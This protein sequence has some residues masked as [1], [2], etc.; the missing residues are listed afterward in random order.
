MND[1]TRSNS[2]RDPRNMARETYC[3]VEDLDHAVSEELSLDVD[4]D[5]IVICGMGGSAIGGDILADCAFSISDFPIK[6][7]RF[8]ELPSWINDRTLVIVSS[9]SG[10]TRETI[11]MYEQAVKRGCTTIVITSGG[12]LKE[13]AMTNKNMIINIKEGL[14]PRNALGFTMGYMANVID[15]V[16]GPK[17]KAGIK[18]L[19]PVLTKLRN[20]LSTFDNMNVAKTV[21]IKIDGCIPVIYST[22]GINASAMRWKTQINENSKMMAFNGTITEFNHSEIVGWSEGTITNM[23]CVPIVLYEENVSKMMK[24]MTDASIKT[25]KKSGVD[26]QVV[27]IKGKTTLERSLRA[28]MIGDYVSLQ[29]AYFKGVDPAEVRIINSFKQK[30]TQLLTR[31]KPK[32]ANKKR[33]KQC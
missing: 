3:F 2:D 15:T 28:I 13:M 16:G 23:R 32:Y 24:Q 17:Y 14:Q 10:N 22:T 21:A 20:R 11:S 26:M 30:I 1:D 19:I 25:L 6:V 5:K 31:K 4:F 29:L 7:L 18:K 12:K 8:P 9:Y 27:K 33:K